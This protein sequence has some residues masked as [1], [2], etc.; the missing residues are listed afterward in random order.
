MVML[1]A[2]LCPY[3]PRHE[4]NDLDFGFQNLFT[5]YIFSRTLFSR[6]SWSSLEKASE[7]LPPEPDIIYIYVR[8]IRSVSIYVKILI[9]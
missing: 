7:L 2:L 8:D 6:K 1:I 5:C 3:F 4:V 9:Q